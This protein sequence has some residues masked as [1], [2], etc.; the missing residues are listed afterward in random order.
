MGTAV[1]SSTDREISTIGPD[2]RI[3][4][5]EVTS[6][7]KLTAIYRDGMQ[8]NL[9]FSELLAAGGVMDP[10]RDA[11]LFAQ[12]KIVRNGRAIEFPGNVDFC[13]DALRLQALTG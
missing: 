7:F 5:L 4:R 9:D 2:N 11:T 10:L 12:V 3:E 6:A 13:A 1:A 8:V